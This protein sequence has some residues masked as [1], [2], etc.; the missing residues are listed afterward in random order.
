MA[1]EGV[2]AVVVVERVGSGPVDQRRIER[3]DALV[4]AEYDR[5]P[6]CGSERSDD[7]LRGRVAASRERDADSIE[8]ADLGPVH[9][10]LGQ[11]LI[12]HRV[13]ALGE[14]EC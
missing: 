10:V 8:D 9:R 4:A 12:A 2:I 3:V 14:F 11:I 5:R 1:A 6:W 13:D 7:D